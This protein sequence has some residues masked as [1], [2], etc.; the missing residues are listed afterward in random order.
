MKVRL[1]VLAAVESVTCET[2]QVMLPEV[3]AVTDGI[4]LSVGT[5][6]VALDEHPVVNEAV[7]VKVPHTVTP[8]GFCT[9]DV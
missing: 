8:V 1:A 2:E 4:E 9:A 7:T 5:S 6:T 3:D